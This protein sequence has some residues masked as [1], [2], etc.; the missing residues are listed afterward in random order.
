M[1]YIF[2]FFCG[3]ST[4]FAFVILVAGIALAAHKTLDASFVGLAGVI[5]A[6][7]TARAIS[8]DHKPGAGDGH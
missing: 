6:L 3:R 1:N 5:Q 8:D 2:S 7:V 4:F